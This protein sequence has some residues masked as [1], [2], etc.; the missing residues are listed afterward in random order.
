MVLD[1]PLHGLEPVAVLL[2]FVI[3]HALHL[4]PHLR[5]DPEIDDGRVLR[6]MAQPGQPS[7]RWT[8]K[9]ATSSNRGSASQVTS[10]RR[11]LRYSR[12]E[13]TL[14]SSLSGPA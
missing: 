13:S 12:S 11:Q 5:V 14:T 4:A 2:L 8:A 6:R 10:F 7:T 3:G 9:T 1:A